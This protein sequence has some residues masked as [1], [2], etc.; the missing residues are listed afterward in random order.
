[1]YEEYAVYL[2]VTCCLGMEF[3]YEWAWLL[4]NDAVSEK[5]AFPTSFPFTWN[6]E[7]F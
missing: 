5:V 3:K 7:L 1:M 2:V 4:T 6:N